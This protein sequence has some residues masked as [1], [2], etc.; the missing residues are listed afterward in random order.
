[1][2]FALR[3][4]TRR[5]HVGTYTAA[6]IDK[7]V[8]SLAAA[9]DGLA[10]GATVMVGG[11]GGS[12][13]PAEL[14]S[15]LRERGTRDL[16]LVANNAGTAATG[17]GVL[18]ANRQVRKLICSFPLGRHVREGMETFW[19]LY[20]AGALQVEILPQGTLVERIRA[21]GAGIP[22]FYTPTGPGTMLARDKEIRTIGGRAC[23]LETAIVAEFALVRAA[24]AD[25]TGNLVYRRAQRNFNTA[26]ATAART[27]VAE[28]YEVVAAGALDPEVIAT[29]GIFVDRVVVVA[30]DRPSRRVYGQAG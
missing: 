29:P 1:V 7:R 25:R 22:A 15:A 2:R 21:G 19:D 17:V 11:F 24:I 6:V 12:G 9:L 28:V 8:A 27:T 16:T 5:V 14:V 13:Y 26:M 20:H 30:D 23:V 3:E 10:D 4:S 18:I